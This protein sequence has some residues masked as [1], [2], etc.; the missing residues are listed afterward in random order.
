MVSVE[1]IMATTFV[2]GIQGNAGSSIK[3][4]IFPTSIND[5]LTKFTLVSWSTKTEKS[6]FSGIVLTRSTVQAWIGKTSIGLLNFASITSSQWWTKTSE[7]V[8]FLE[9]LTTFLTRIGNARILLD[10]APVSGIFRLAL[11]SDVLKQ[12]G[13]VENGIAGFGDF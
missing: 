7:R 8:S 11:A 10:L 3:A 13:T 2:I 5:S 6:V 1:V 9:T 4:R 12:N